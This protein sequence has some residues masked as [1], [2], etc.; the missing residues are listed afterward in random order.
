MLIAP[1]EVVKMPREKL[2]ETIWERPH[3]YLKLLCDR[4]D[5]FGAVRSNHIHLVYGDWSEQLAE[6]CSIVD[7]KPVVLK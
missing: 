7:I 1:V 5:F 6:A 2:K 3:A 4:D